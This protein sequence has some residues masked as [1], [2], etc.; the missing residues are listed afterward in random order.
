MKTQ[1]NPLKSTFQN[2]TTLQND[3]IYI[4]KISNN[5]T[6]KIIITSINNNFAKN[7]ILEQN[8]QHIF[9]TVN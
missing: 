8:T 2:Y 4:L 6:D 5:Q 7:S 3:P 9:H 1:A